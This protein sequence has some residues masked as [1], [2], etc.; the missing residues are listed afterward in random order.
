MQCYVDFGVVAM[1][2][3]E[4]RRG[5]LRRSCVLLSLLVVLGSKTL[6]G[7]SQDIERF[8]ESENW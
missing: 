7:F 2:V 6:S 1:V 4:R 5:S 3:N 8:Q